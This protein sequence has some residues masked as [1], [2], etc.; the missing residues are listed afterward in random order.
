MQAN[1]EQNLRDASTNLATKVAGWVDTNVRL[2]EQEV[3]SRL[4]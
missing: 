1:A 2:L 4:F 3:R